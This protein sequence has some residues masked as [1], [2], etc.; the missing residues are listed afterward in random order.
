MALK[1]MLV[2]HSFVCRFKAF[3]REHQK[4]FNYNLNLCPRQ[5]MLQYAGKSGGTVQSVREEKLEAV[6]DFD[7]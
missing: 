1:T 5:F 3:L 4:D 6:A 2:G 7:P